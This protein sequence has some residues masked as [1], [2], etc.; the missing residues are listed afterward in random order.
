MLLT[1]DK[2]ALEKKVRTLTGEIY[3]LKERYSP[4]NLVSCSNAMQEV[5]FLLRKVASLK[6]VVLLL[7]EK[8]VEKETV[9]QSLH[10]DGLKTM[11]PFLKLN[12]SL[13]PPEELEVLLFGEE[14]SI[15]GEKSN[16]HPG[17]LE[18]AESGSLFIDDVDKLPLR[19]QAK[20]L[21]ALKDRTFEKAPGTGSIPMNARLIVG[22]SVD[23][24]TMVNHGLFIENL[25]YRLNVFPITIPPLREREEDIVRLSRHFL[26]RFSEELNKNITSFSPQA[27]DIL[28]SYAWP[29][30]VS[31]LEN[32]IRQTVIIAEDNAKTIEPHDLPTHI[33][34]STTHR[35]NPRLGLVERMDSLERDLIAEA[36]RH[37]R[38]NIS[39]AA[40]DLELT[41]RSMG[42]RMKR[43]NLNY[44]DFR[45]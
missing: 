28:R 22:T 32:V 29:L 33:R 16:S 45:V 3:E 10:Y 21:E 42:L 34:L 17:L 5:Y 41:R 4:S 8:G 31:E 38:G 25:Y 20:L 13:Y 26:T 27:L 14:S 9:A 18:S 24:A 1:I 39:R 30:N 6:T 43:L 7:G 23:L 19:A 44:K 35:A 37:H 11:G 40:K 15:I 2:I 12:C 36:L